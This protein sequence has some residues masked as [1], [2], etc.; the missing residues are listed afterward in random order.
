M[1]EVIAFIN[2]KVGY[3]VEIFVSETHDDSVN[4][5]QKARRLGIPLNRV[6]IDKKTL[7]MTADTVD[8]DYKLYP[9]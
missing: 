2:K 7:E 3:E 6:T 8:Y 9:D 5:H 4:L 1:Q